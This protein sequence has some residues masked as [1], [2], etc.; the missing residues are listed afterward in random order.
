MN[1]TTA[2]WWRCS[3][4]ITRT[5]RTAWLMC[6]IAQ[7]WPRRYDIR[8][9]CAKHREHGVSE[10]WSSHGHAW[11]LSLRL[12]YLHGR[13]RR[14]RRMR[15]KTAA[16]TPCFFGW[17]KRLFFGTGYKTKQDR[18]F[19][20]STTIRRSEA[21]F[22]DTIQSLLRSARAFEENYDIRFVDV[23]TTDIVE[24]MK[25]SKF[26]AASCWITYLCNTRASK[27][28]IEYQDALHFLG[29]Q[30]TDALVAKISG[31]TPPD[32]PSL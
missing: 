30:R 6:S 16:R 18:E 28:L 10:R 5:L 19:F 9:Y 14:W 4:T 21:T 2:S 7:P 26:S 25:S 27:M 1:H 15:C 23:R 29:K 24:V 3:V 20:L 32:D 11:R 22:E 12:L 31:I 17:R 8:D 13:R